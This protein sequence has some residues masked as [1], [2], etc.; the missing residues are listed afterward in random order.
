MRLPL[1]L[2]LLELRAVRVGLDLPLSVLVFLE[3]ALLV[4]P[5]EEVLGIERVLRLGLLELELLL[6]LPVLLLQL[7]CPLLLA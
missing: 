2:G 7:V 5:S 4:E 3:L 1:D 6:E